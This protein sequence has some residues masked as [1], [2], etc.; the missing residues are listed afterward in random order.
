MGKMFL[1]GICNAREGGAGEGLAK[2]T[3]TTTSMKNI[4]CLSILSAGLLLC[5]CDRNETRV[6]RAQDRAAA[7]ADSPKGQQ[8]K[9]DW[10]ITKGKLKQ[11]FAQLTDD[12]LMYERG[13]ED[14]LYGRLEKKLGKTREEVVNL[15][16]GD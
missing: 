6:E 8:V 3:H 2:N 1:D 10:N 12:D 5:S 11:K 16:N 7:S 14:E 4:V 15:V 9:G 13:K